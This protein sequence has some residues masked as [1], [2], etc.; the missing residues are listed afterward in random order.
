[1]IYKFRIILDADGDIFR[2]I[3]IDGDSTFESFHNTITQA[4]GFDGTEMASF[5]QSDEEWHQGE[6][7][8]LFDMGETPGG[9]LLMANTIIDTLVNENDNRLLYVYDFFH[10][11]TFFIELAEIAEPDAGATYPQLL[12]SHGLLPDTP[13]EKEFKAE[14]QEDPL[15]DNLN[16][17]D[18]DDLYHDTNWN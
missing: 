16:D 7:I 17:E 13:P 2:D 6:E 4:F 9:V 11:W 1:M 14:G 18:L 15:S 8:A 10:M 5:Y 12:Y 3:A